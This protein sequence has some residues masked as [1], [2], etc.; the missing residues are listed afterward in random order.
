MIT[1]GLGHAAAPDH[2]YLHLVTYSSLPFIAI[3]T[4][5]F[6]YKIHKSLIKE[7]LLFDELQLM[8]NKLV[9]GSVKL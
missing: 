5:V 3:P 6:E 2:F 4:H 8:S 7:K 1:G 9:N